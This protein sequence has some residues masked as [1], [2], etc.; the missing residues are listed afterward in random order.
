MEFAEQMSDPPIVGIGASAS[1]IKALQQLVEA[2]PGD[3]G[4]AYVVVVDVPPAQHLALADILRP[5]TAMPVVQADGR[6]RLSRNHVYLIAPDAAMPA[7]GVIVLP[8]PPVD[9]SLPLPD[10][11][12]APRDARIRQLSAALG[13]AQDQ[14]RLTREEAD[15]AKRRLHAANEALQRLNGELQQKLD[16]VSRACSDLENFMAATDIATLILDQALCIQR[17]TPRLLELFDISA[18]DVGRPIDEFTHQLE[19][20]GLA[21]HSREVLRTLMPVEHEVM[22]RDGGWYLVRIRPHRT[23]DGAVGGVICTFVAITERRRAEEALRES[24]ERLRQEMRL[25]EVTRSPIFVWDF[26]GG[27]LQWNRGSEQLYGYRREEALGQR[28]DILLHTRVPGSTFAELRQTLLA[29][30][31]WSGELV[32]RAKDGRLLT[33]ESQIELV[34]MGGRHLVLESTRDIT[35]YKLWEE[36]QQL[37]LGELTHR[38]KNALTVVQSLARQTLRTTG[39]REDLIERFEG[40]LSALAAAYKLLV[41][42]DWQG[43]ELGV[44]ARSQ[45]NAYAGRQQDRL[46]IRG[47]PVML[48]PDYATPFGLVL[49][50]LATNAAKYGALSSEAGRVALSWELGGRNNSHHRLTVIW[51]E[52]GGPPVNAPE[53]RGFGTA[54]IGGGIPGSSVRHEFRREGVVCTIEVDLPPGEAD[55]AV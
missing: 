30:G 7:A 5:R 21:D 31:S 13:L 15:L 29:R 16:T 53:H 44:L 45:L 24:E 22:S 18:D 11:A 48:P 9:A 47:N 6:Q 1:G 3:T 35:D 55:T 17:F 10:D 51:K 14:I 33:V 12:A 41:E 27:I 36:R 19:Y 4:A 52:R 42:T 26:N 32:H 40:R 50:E 49:H 39:S 37:L 28:K 54:L 25:V 23:I 38:V 2:I 46:Q 8:L 34:E 20:D 43:A